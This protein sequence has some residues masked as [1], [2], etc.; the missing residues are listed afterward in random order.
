MEFKYDQDEV[1]KLM[2]Q[3]LVAMGFPFTSHDEALKETPSRVARFLG[4]FCVPATLADILKDGFTNITHEGGLIVQHNIPFKG[5]CQHHLLPFFGEAHVGYIPGKKVAGLSKLA[6]VV[7]AAG[8]IKPSTQEEVTDSIAN[9]LQ[10]ALDP[11]GVM[12]VTTAVHTCMA[13][14]GVNVPDTRTTMSSI[15][16]NFVHVPAARAEF[17]SLLRP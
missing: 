13:V 9:A 11:K 2:A 12:V 5:L 3:V 17:L 7:R 10:Q 6:R 1:E 15:R 16:G 8:T 4:E 14:R